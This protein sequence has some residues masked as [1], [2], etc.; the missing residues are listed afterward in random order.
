MLN[1][2]LRRKDMKGHTSINLSKLIKELV[3]PL[4]GCEWRV[5]GWSS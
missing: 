5:S 2:S 4:E 1:Q 3:G